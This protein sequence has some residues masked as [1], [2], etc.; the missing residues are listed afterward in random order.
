MA[1]PVLGLYNSFQLTPQEQ[2][3]GQTFSGLNQMF[4]QNLRMD[5]VVLRNNMIPDVEKP[6]VYFLNKAKYD[7]IIE[8]LTYLI[9][10]Q[11]G[12]LAEDDPDS[13]HL[14]NLEVQP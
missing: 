11:P 5:Y 4:L 8:I 14:V 7:G 13:E 9:D 6:G 2:V 1:T 10:I 12:N 3:V